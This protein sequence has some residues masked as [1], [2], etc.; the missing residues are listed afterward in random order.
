[1]VV[2]R[3]VLFLLLPLT[4][5]MILSSLIPNLEVRT[6]YSSFTY[7]GFYSK[8]YLITKRKEIW[9]VDVKKVEGMCL[10]CCSLALGYQRE[11]TPL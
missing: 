5:Y 11:E 7:I 3:L 9:E 8:L 6:K 4:Y 1:M 2:R 10:H